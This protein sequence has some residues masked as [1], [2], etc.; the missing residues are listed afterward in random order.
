MQQT[1]IEANNQPSHQ[2]QRTHSTHQYI[3]PPQI[4]RPFALATIRFPSH[5]APHHLRHAF[6][7]VPARHLLCLVPHAV[8]HNAHVR[9][10]GDSLVSL[11]ALVGEVPEEARFPRA[12]LPYEH[13]L[14]PW[15]SLRPAEHR[16]VV[17]VHQFVH[18][19]GQQRHL[20]LLCLFRG[21]IVA[22]NLSAVQEA[23]D[24]QHHSE[25][26]SSHFEADEWSGRGGGRRGG[27][28]RG[29]RCR[30]RRR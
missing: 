24:K 2:R 9:A 7:E 3:P 16:L 28:R 10:V 12:P 18:T 15:D 21:R 8:A 14:R 20:R 25:C 27:R 6:V 4:P 26:S 22:A 30:W 13:Q 29:G 1:W 23:E 19:N 17:R 11:E 5:H